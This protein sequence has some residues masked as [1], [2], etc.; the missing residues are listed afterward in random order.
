MRTARNPERILA[1]LVAGILF[2]QS[3]AQTQTPFSLDSAAAYLR[4][5]AVDIGPRPMGSPAERLAMQYAV[6]KFHEFG[7]SEAYIM[8]MNAVEG[9]GILSQ[10]TNTQSGVAVGVLRGRTDR[11]IVL[12]AHI[13]TGGPEIPGA[14]DDG[15]GCAVVME[16][17]RVLSQRKNESTIVVALFGGEERGLKGSRFF[18]ENFAQIDQVILMLQVDMANGSDW[19][20]PLVDTQTHSAPEWLVGAA[21][22]EF[23]RLGYNGLSF[24]SHF[25]T[26][27]SAMPGGGIGSDHMP[28]L[29]KNIPA[30]DFTSD[31]SDPIHTAQ[32]NY[33]NFKPDGLKRSGDLVFR[34]V[35]RFDGG[36]PEKTS[37]QYYL[38]QIG[39]TPIFVPRWLLRVFLLISLIVTFFALARVRQRREATD[40]TKK[41]KI[42]GLKLFLLALIIQACVWLSENVVSLIKGVRH[43]WMANL[44]GYFVLGFFA[45]LFGIWIALQLAPRLRLRHDAYS[46]F[47]RAVIFLLV[48][49]ILSAFS[50]SKLALYPAVSLF[51][52]S[53]AL[54]VR[55]PL[56]KLIFWLLSPH[57]MFRLFFSEGFGFLARAGYS[58]V[59]ITPAVSVWI[60]L[61]YILFFSIWSFP[62]LLGFASV[63]LDAKT[64]L[65][66]LKQFRTRWGLIG[67]ALACVITIIVLS[68]Q[69]SYTQYWRPNIRVEQTFDADSATGTLVVESSEYLTGAR[70]QVGSI[71]TTIGSRATRLAFHSLAAP[72]EK[73]VR[74]ERDVATTRTDSGTTFRLLLKLHTRYRPYTLRVT[75]AGGE[76]EL[77]DILTPLTSATLERSLTLLWYSFPD[78]ML[79]IP[80]QFTVVGADSIIERVDATLAEPAVPM[81]I[82]TK[83]DANVSYRSILSRR[84]ALKQERR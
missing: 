16:L 48:F 45:A 40:Q 6:Q 39:A 18:V 21:Y 19:L 66:W 52:L 70:I 67:S 68:A 75:Y 69:P 64:D 83:E 79:L 14:N 37:D 44:D 51:L 62:F 9:T 57:F 78:T 17:A 61:L 63:Y 53:L 23:S 27:M 58:N 24:P 34:L 65:L 8:P 3:S 72:A 31:P 4:V 22:E 54:L 55:Q 13:D 71:D 74:T 20:L 77:R 41:P 73:W 47:L 60:H 49:F 29:D 5:I 36:T 15:S 46:Y 26:L 12:G 28:F 11:I 25:L 7:L 50:S 38:Y 30:I 32:D 76:H 35:E 42:P 80:V 10:A 84:T 33:E 59:E 1:G 81:E 2:F 82:S 43:P 56:L